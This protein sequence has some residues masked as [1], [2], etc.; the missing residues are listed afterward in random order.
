MDKSLDV[1]ALPFDEMIGREWLATNALG[2]FAASTV[3]C[4]N[5]RKYHGLLVAAMAPPVRRM[6]L[7]SRVEETL[8]RDG[9]P[10]PLA[11]SEYPGTIHPEGYRLLRAFDHQ[12]T[13]RWLYQ[14]DGWTVEKSLHLLRHHNTVCLAYTLLGGDQPLDFELRPLLAL[15]PIHDLMY[16]WNGRLTVES[17]PVAPTRQG[18]VHGYSQSHSHRVPATGRTPEVFFAH[19]GTFD[20]QATWYF[21][22]IYRREQERGYR[23]LE[24]LWMPGVVRYALA[25]GKTVYFACSADP[26]DLAAVVKQVHGKDDAAGALSVSVASAAART[27]PP[28]AA[29]DAIRAGLAQ[30]ADTFIVAVPRDGSLG[31]PGA[32]SVIAQYPWSPPQPR[33]ALIGFGGLFL[34]TGR[35]DEGAA[36]LNSLATRL[37]DGL[38]PSEFPE[39][40]SAPLYHGAD[41]SLWFVSAVHQ[42]LRRGGDE[43]LVRRQLY[44]PVV[45]ILDH[46]RAGTRLGIKPDP[47]GIISTSEPGVGTTW[48][49]CKS[50]DGASTPRAGRPVELNALWYNALRIGAE[51]SERFGHGDRAADYTA[52]ADSVH[53]AFNR[54][55]WNPE[56]VCCFDVV[57]DDPAHNDGSI[58]PNQLLAASLPFPVLDIG[59]HELVL[60]WLTTALL[61]PFG[62]RT[63][64]PDDANYQGRY[65]GNAT[66]RDRAH[67]NGP[68]YP[69][70]LGQLVTTFVRVRGRGPAARAAA[71]AMLRPSLDHQAGPGTGQLPE[72]FDGDPPHLPGGAPASALSVAELLRCYAEDIAD[73]VPTTDSPALTLTLGD[74]SNIAPTPPATPRA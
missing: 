9:W 33:D 57:A 30:A 53:D 55:F 65:G 52:L 7:L 3:P 60:E 14:G 41:V 22:T 21:N 28:A 13:P 27:T 10:F 6:V 17:A 66:S 23:G 35:L 36:L 63:L 19:D 54:R 70:L 12:P 50:A 37:Q 62:V 42:Y 74:L 67:H 48:M 51:L 15:R 59:R 39:D 69:W 71:Q 68:A 46:Y 43:A 24:D 2:G 16:Q 47:D 5:T 29:G 49:N 4:V 32:V 72:L 25:P 40:G 58:R 8:F 11:S 20:P 26:I 38:L 18:N 1:S 31:T 61:T 44:E 34:A 45:R 73:E 56:W 64:A